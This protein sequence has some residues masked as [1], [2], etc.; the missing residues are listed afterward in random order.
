MW[1]SMR[2]WIVAM[3]GLLGVGCAVLGTALMRGSVEPL[4]VIGSSS[5]PAMGLVGDIVSGI[6][7]DLLGHAVSGSAGGTLGVAAG[8]L[9]RG[10][11][12]LGAEPKK[13]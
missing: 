2:I 9:L 13:V 8:W 12:G 11:R 5:Q 10:R 7:S 1:K 6:W 4:W 3:L